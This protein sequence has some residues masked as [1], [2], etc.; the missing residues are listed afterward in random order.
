MN[1]PTIILFF[2]YCYGLGFA[3][4]F[5]IKQKKDFFETHIMRIGIGL[6][7]IPVLGV[8][9]NLL[10]IPLDWRLFLGLSLLAPLILT[11]KSK[12]MLKIDMAELK[13]KK[14]DLMFLVAWLLFLFTL[15][16]YV[17]G[18]FK[19]PYLEDDDSWG[20]AM[21]IKFV[22]IEKTLD[23]Y[24]N[25]IKFLD[26]Y[27]P[28]YEF[29][30]GILHQTSPSLMWTM[31]FFN[32]LI[33]ALGILFF[34]FLV[35]R[36]S[37]SST[38]ALYSTI[39]LTFI[40][41]YMSHFIW[42]HSLAVTLFF[43]TF[44]CLE[45][46][47][48]DKRWAYPSAFV[49]SGILLAQPT[50][51]MKFVLLFLLYLLIKFLFDRKSALYIFL[52]ALGGSLLSLI[53]WFEKWKGFLLYN[54]DRNIERLSTLGT[55]ITPDANSS[56]WQR[57]FSF[58]QR[59]F[60]SG[61]GTADRVYSFDDFF[62]AK[63]QNMINNPVGVGAI[64][65]LLLFA[66]LSYLLIRYYKIVKD[67]KKTLSS[68]LFYFIMALVIIGVLSILALVFKSLLGLVYLTITLIFISFILTKKG[69]IEKKEQYLLIMLLWLLFT[70]LGVNSVTFNLPVGLFA[71]RFWMLFAIPAS[72]LIGN[73][74]FILM[75]YAKSIEK[76]FNTKYLLS[77]VLL[78]ILLFGIWKTSGVQKYTVNTAMWG[79]GGAWTSM[80][81]VQGYVWLKTLPVDTK[82]YDFRSDGFIIGFDKFSCFWCEG[83]KEY[84]KRI[85][86]ENAT[87][88]HKWLKGKGYEYAIVGGMS[89]Q[90]GEEWHGENG[91]KLMQ[92][93]ID[94][95]VKSGLFP[96]AH[97]TEGMA[98]LKVT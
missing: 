23:D 71:F 92:E 35:F 94:E 81:E 22:S 96:V 48:E 11:I 79:P 58:L 34:Y 90:K 2:L 14:S 26:P 15:S 7:A 73:M 38:K 41:C 43:P 51:A 32:A 3:L 52:S 10:R 16:M 91:T 67:N 46:I 57:L 87:D 47:K 98:V 85:V 9:L 6:G 64:L 61:T 77:G 76:Q 66:Y 63:F 97:Q 28:G 82:V 54:I 53:W 33:I 5:F 65:C 25:S 8:I 31:K 84:R 45:R 44:Y 27:P 12:N 83:I 17:S 21:G 78:I 68:H 1:L 20:H 40:P 42:A 39:V 72:V 80:E 36:F 75:Q 62:I 13:V 95:L 29:V 70:F 49:L 37:G 89:I 50:Q 88:I 59:I 60:P 4:T 93:K 55:I 19:Y 74:V 24:T 18:A 86:Y 56:F 30:M 69:C